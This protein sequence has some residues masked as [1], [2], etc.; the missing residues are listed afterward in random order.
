MLETSEK[1]ENLINEEENIDRI[2][3]NK[4]KEVL[5]KENKISNTQTDNGLNLEY[6]WNDLY[7]YPKNS[8]IKSSQV[9][10]DE[11]NENNIKYILKNIKG[12]IRSGEAL[13]II[14]G[15]G[16]GK[17]TLLNVLSRKIESK[18]LK[19]SGEVKINNMESTQTI[20]DSISS[21]V[22]QDDVLEANLTPRE[23]L[24]F[25]AKLKLTNIPVN[26][27][28][29]KVENMIEKLNLKNAADTKIGD[30]SFR[31]VSGGERK[32]TSIGVELISDPQ[33]I[34][35]DE[36]TTGLDSFN[37]FEVVTNICKMA[38]EEKKIIVFTIHQPSSEIFNLLDKICILAD[39]KTIYFGPKDDCLP[40][41]S[42]V[43]R[44]PCKES[45]NPFEHFI[46]TTTLE[47]I[48]NEETRKVYPELKT[49]DLKDDTEKQNMYSN[50]M[51]NLSNLFEKNNEKN[52]EEDEKLVGFNE[53]MENLLK[54]KSETR[55]FCY[56]FWALL[57]RNIMNSYRNKKVLFFK[58]FQNLFTSTVQSIL[59]MN[60]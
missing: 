58:M 15:S 52:T 45:Y 46:D 13:A 54:L 22:M 20:L 29:M 56:E 55:G 48:Y 10:P 42:D 7:V 17:T 4:P 49:E 60:V 30:T 38:K 3:E 21:Y 11:N 53:K 47:C 41:F 40:C 51:T 35:L 1:T 43:F 16:A 14:G 2:S 24:L 39:G 50:H 6:S 37:A 33:I 27:I 18:N 28:E 8:K 44:L 12:K 23:I 9:S 26:E 31:G 34:F 59:Y 36:P 5:K 25:T 19:I 32:R 57:G